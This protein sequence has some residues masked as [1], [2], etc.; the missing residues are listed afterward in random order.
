RHGA[1]FVGKTR[2]FI[3]NNASG[4]GKVVNEHNQRSSNGKQPHHLH[5]FYSEPSL[6]CRQTTGHC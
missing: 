3:H 6:G 2:C 1:F 4:V 5:I